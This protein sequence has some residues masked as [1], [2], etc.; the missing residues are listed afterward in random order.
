MPQLHLKTEPMHVIGSSWAESLDYEPMVG[1]FHFCEI[2]SSTYSSTTKSME[3]TDRRFAHAT[4]RCN[5][6]VQCGVVPC[7]LH[8]SLLVSNALPTHPPTHPPTPPTAAPSRTPT[9]ERRTIASA[10]YEETGS[11]LLELH[12]AVGSFHNQTQLH[13]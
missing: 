5:G 11:N 4:G 8:L 13:L 12:N 10:H 1:S 2:P 3:R 7:T 6:V 9:D